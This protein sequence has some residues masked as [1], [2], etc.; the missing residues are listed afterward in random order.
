MTWGGRRKLLY[1]G[2]L[3][4]VVAL[5][6]LAYI[7]PKIN[8]A[9][10]CVDQKQN[11]AEHGIDCGGN[12][13]KICQ[14]EAAPLVVKWTR[15]FKVADGYYNAFSY[16]ENQNIQAASQTLYY[17]FSLYDSDNVFITS[18]S[19]MTYV[20][21]NGQFGIFE[22]AIATG[23][24]I[25]KNTSI[26]LVNDPQW[27]KISQDEAK[28]SIF[29]E[30]SVPTNLDIAPKLSVSIENSTIT[31]VKNVDVFAIVY[32]EAGNA[33]GVSK[34]ILDVVPANAKRTATFTWREPFAGEV[35]KTEIINQ[36]N[37]FANR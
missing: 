29:A 21:P 5:L 27:L 7:Y 4:I 23:K 30:A 28:Q 24:R 12:C 2:I 22:P 18:R 32:G 31:P 13:V 11:G 14:A 26:K 35:K 9:A 6:L 1:G 36:V 17:E 8:V 3:C 33:L 10:T 15:S 25:P 37:V 16:V 19:G 34:T 20:P